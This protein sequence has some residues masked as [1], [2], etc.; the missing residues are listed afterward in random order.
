MA[1][2]LHFPHP[3]I[4][5]PKMRDLNLLSPP[6]GPQPVL[7]RF[8]SHVNLPLTAQI[9]MYAQL[10]EWVT[11]DPN[12]QSL[13]DH[14][15]CDTTRLPYLG[16]ATAASSEYGTIIFEVENA[17]GWCL[18]Q[19]EFLRR[20]KPRVS[21][22]V[23]VQDLTVLLAHAPLTSLETKNMDVPAETW[24]KL[25][26]TFPGLLSV[27]LL[28][29]RY[30]SRLQTRTLQMLAHTKVVME[31]NLRTLKVY[32][33]ARQAPRFLDVLAKVLRRR[34]DRGLPPLSELLIE[35]RTLRGEKCIDADDAF[36]HE[37]ALAT[38]R[39]L[40]DDTVS[41]QVVPGR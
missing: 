29:D 35:L 5:F 8:L 32:P 27:T 23:H 22:G 40:V 20:D 14:I 39:S 11:Q 38:L 33:Y 34:A 2:G 4:S 15:P 6:T 3:A 12:P 13:L 19:L 37:P 9:H 31:T 26:Q 21:R 36:A 41:Y 25:W 30:S 16:A 17:V 24:F 7:Y 28:C 1:A 10:D 18:L